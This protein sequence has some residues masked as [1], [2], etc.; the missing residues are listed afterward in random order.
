[1]REDHVAVAREFTGQT[2]VLEGSRL[3]LERFELIETLARSDAA[4]VHIV[5]GLKIKCPHITVCDTQY[6]ETNDLPK[7]K[8]GS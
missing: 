8:G 1:M 2:E 3:I 4:A 6:N 5:N 7:Y